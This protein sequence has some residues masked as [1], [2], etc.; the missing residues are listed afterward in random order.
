M[1]GTTHQLDAGGVRL[2]VTVCTTCEGN[3]PNLTR[4]AR[5]NT[6]LGRFTDCVKI[7]ECT[8]PDHH[9]RKEAVGI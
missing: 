3:D 1:Y 5:P 2:L 8:H 4:I 6:H 9:D 7:A